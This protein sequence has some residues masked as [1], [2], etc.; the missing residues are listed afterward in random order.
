MNRV[1]FHTGAGAFAT[2]LVM[3]PWKVLQAG[4]MAEERAASIAG[5]MLA[6]AAAVALAIRRMPFAQKSFDMPAFRE[7]FEVSAFLRAF[8]AYSFVLIALGVGLY[9]VYART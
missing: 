4:G 1:R 7:R 3:I 9:V 5:V 6:I 8:A 2:L